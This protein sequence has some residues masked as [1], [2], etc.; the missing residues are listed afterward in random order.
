M[1]I[2]ELYYADH[3]QTQVVV[4]IL[5][6]SILISAVMV[7]THVRVSQLLSSYCPD[8][9]LIPSNNRLVLRQHTGMILPAQWYRNVLINSP[10]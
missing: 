2:V 8:G 6:I 1:W 3:C 9:Y 7:G 5:L 4:H 10:C